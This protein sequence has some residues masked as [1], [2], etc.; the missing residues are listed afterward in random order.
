[1]ESKEDVINQEQ[2]KIDIFKV[3]IT[4]KIYSWA[5]SWAFNDHSKGLGVYQHHA[6]QIQ[7]MFSMKM[8]HLNPFNF[9]LYTH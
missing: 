1:M 5:H 7:R 2:G 9:H 4:I 6:V 3:Q 8:T